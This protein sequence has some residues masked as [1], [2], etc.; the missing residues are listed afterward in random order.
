MS[1]ITSPNIYKAV[2]HLNKEG[3]IA[4][5]TEGLYG[6]GCNPFSQSAVMKLLEIKKRSVRRGLIL[7]ASDFS[8]IRPLI[9]PLPAY[10]K[11]QVMETWPG[12]VTWLFPISNNTPTWIKGDHNTIAI[13]ISNHPII[14]ALCTIN[15]GPIVSTSANISG[16]PSIRDLR[17]I[18]ICF[19][20][21]V[22]Y[23]VQGNLGNLKGATS[24]RDALT[25]ENIR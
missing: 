4:Y 9:T 15:N 16:Y 25:G 24:I 7:V 23:I 1:A 6:L 2:E 22:D 12:P 14:Q 13:R 3:V 11:A 20:D 5:P 19:A 21:K 17:S 18:Q 8:Q 10:A